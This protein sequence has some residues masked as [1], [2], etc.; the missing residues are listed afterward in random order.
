MNLINR[1]LMPVLLLAALL[2]GCQKKQETP[3]LAAADDPAIVNVSPELLKRLTVSAVGAGEIAEIVRVPARVEVDE[4]RVARIGAA[5]TGRLTEIRAELG[6]RVRRGD[7]LATLHSAELSSS[8]LAYLKAV[9]QEGQ[10]MRAVTRAKLLFEADVISSAELQKR[11]S[12]LLQAQ[13]ERQTSHDQLKVLGMIEADISKLTETRLVHSLSSVIAT[14]DGAVIERK[15]T[16]G[17]VV[18]PADALF[19]IA[20]LSH[21]W[22]VAEIP[23]QQAGLVRAGGVTE[24]EISALADQ[25]IKGKLIFVSDTVKPDTRTVTVRMDVENADRL[26]KPGMLASMLIRGAPHKRVMLPMVAIVREENRDYVFV[27]L[28]AHRFQLRQIKLGQES[29]GGAPVLE[30]LLEGE[31][32]VTEGAFHLNNERRRKELEG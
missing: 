24:A 12:E 11:E 23:E 13:A 5:V 4:Q 2:A 8:Q 1:Y 7:V 26:I 20:D 28:D 22:L 19:T 25:D 17:Q 14:L 31:K 6:Q 29:G 10:Q 18:Q 3:V 15:V 9:S 21:V 27:Q 32:I 16:Q 30:G